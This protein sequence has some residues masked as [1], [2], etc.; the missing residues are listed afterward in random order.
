MT[1]AS[2]LETE[3]LRLRPLTLDD[4]DELQRLWAEPGVRR[5]LWDDEVLP[6]GRVRAV[7]EQSVASFESEGFGLWAVRAREA[8]ALIGFCGFWFFH[9]PPRLELVYGIAPSLWNRGL[10]TEAARAVL[11]YGFGQLSFAR[12][13]ASTD[14]A[15]VAS[16]RVLER[17][18]MSLRE[19]EPADGPAMLYYAVTR[20]AFLRG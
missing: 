20:E 17:A 19:R 15:N 1:R 3:R 14:A 18:G 11:G 7:V 12:I 10:A 5:Y 16:A 6:R 9:D 8:E 2:T 4:V 13:E